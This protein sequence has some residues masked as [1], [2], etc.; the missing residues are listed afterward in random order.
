M[1]SFVEFLP[2]IFRIPGVTSFLTEKLCQDPLEQFFG[3]QRQKGGTNENPTVKEFSKNTQ[4]LRVINGTCTNVRRGNCRGSKTSYDMEKE[5]APLPRRG[6]KKL[7]TYVVS[8][9]YY[10]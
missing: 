5:S 10:L 1:S 4:V 2:F 9:K 6:Q 8:Y 3:I 7:A